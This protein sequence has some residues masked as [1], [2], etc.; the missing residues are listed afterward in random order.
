MPPYTCAYYLRERL[1]RLAKR[2][3]DEAAKLKKKPQR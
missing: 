3:K 1:E 2:T